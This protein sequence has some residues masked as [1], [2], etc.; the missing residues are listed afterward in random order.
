MR[1]TSKKTV[2]LEEE[3]SIMEALQ[4]LPIYLISDQPTVCPECGLRTLVIGDFFHTNSKSA[5]HQC[6]EDRYIFIE[7]VDEEFE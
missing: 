1:T 7:Q 2:S 5:I 6:E 3:S 4:E